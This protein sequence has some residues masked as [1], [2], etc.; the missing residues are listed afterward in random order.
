MRLDKYLKVSRV[1]K[2]RTLAQELCLGGHVKKNG[3]TAKPS[4]DVQVG[5]LIEVTFGS[6]VISFRVLKTADSADKKSAGEMYEIIAG[7]EEGEDGCRA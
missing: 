5:D 6:R 3:R 1:I 4:A 2:R 7:A